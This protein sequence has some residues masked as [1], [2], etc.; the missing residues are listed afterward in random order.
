MPRRY[1]HAEQHAA[2]LPRA[3]RT[4]GAVLLLCSPLGCGGGGDDTQGAAGAQPLPNVGQPCTVECVTGFVC[5]RAGP[6]AGQCTAGCGS[7]AACQILA[8]D[9][10][11]F[12]M[13]T[14]QCG[15]TCT[16]DAQCPTGTTCQL[17]EGMLGCRIP[18][19]SP[20][21]MPGG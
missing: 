4:L 21:P 2:K 11:C 16:A 7:G 10:A 14:P 6:F 20:P 15:L 17:I 19:A 12:S 3:L 13:S 5:E 18:A 9:T 1:P 8:P